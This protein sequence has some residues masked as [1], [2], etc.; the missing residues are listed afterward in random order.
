MLERDDG[1]TRAALAAMRL[2]RPYEIRIVPD[3]GPRTKPKALNA[4]LPFARGAFV[5]VFDAEDRPEPDQLRRAFEAFATHD[6]RLACV[7]AR[8]TIDN[9]RDNW[10]TGMFTAEYAGLFDV[11]LPGLATHRLPLPLGGSSNYF[12]TAVLRAVGGWDPHNLTEDA[13]LG[14]R[15]ARLGYRSAVI[16]S[17]T[18][19]E[20]PSRLAAWLRQRRRWFQG[21]LQTWFVHMRKPLRLWRELGPAGFVTFQLVVG[22]TVLAALVHPLFVVGFG[23]EFAAAGLRHGEG[24]AGMMLAALAGGT[25]V[26]GYLATVVLGLV[27]LLRRRLSASAWVLLLVPVHWMLLS[28]A[29]WQA[30]YK[31][32]SDP[33][34][35]DKT[36]HGQAR[37]SRM[38]E[39]GRAE[40]IA[41]PPQGRIVAANIRISSQA[42]EAA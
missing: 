38:A 3:I 16:A 9:T 6:E 18:Y 2:R 23:L 21:W 11:L 30:V 37:T 41:Q 5:T 8:L 10:L 35:W 40:W 26:S 7:Q 22:G 13:D 19:E 39:G 29:A 31:L 36:E 20:A 28:L 17:T 25:F 34:R 33:Y 1:E 12:R 4:A 24:A 42:T 15:L 14:M 27:G 32:I